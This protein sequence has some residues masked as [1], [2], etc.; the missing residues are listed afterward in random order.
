MP[1]RPDR[2]LSD[3]EGAG[4]KTQLNLWKVTPA[5]RRK[6]PGETLASPPSSWVTRTSHVTT[7]P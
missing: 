7:E 5:D 3:H 1:G 6:M 2:S 4:R